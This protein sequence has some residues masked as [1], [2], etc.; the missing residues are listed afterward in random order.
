MTQSRKT[1]IERYV[2]ACAALGSRAAQEELVKR[3]HKRFLRHAYRLLG[4]AEQAREAVQDGWLEILRGL[5]GLRDEAAFAAWAFRIVTRKCARHISAARRDRA[6]RQA[7]I[8]ASDGVGDD[9]R[10]IE[11]AADRVPVR[12]ALMRLPAGQRAAVAL[13]YLEEMRVAEV[14]VALDIPVG[15]VK[16]RLLN[17]R[18][19]LRV[20]LDAPDEEGE[21]LEQTRQADQ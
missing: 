2:V 16:S 11:L 3:Y 1:V 21:D 12:T 4:N 6:A 17:A 9:Q 15:T 8:D 13:F 18:R 5:A 10:R 20:A 7:L 19:K 14:A